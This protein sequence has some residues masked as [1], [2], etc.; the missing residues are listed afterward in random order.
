MGKAAGSNSRDDLHHWGK[1]MLKVTQKTGDKNFF[2]S[3]HLIYAGFLLQFKGEEK[4]KQLLDQGIRIAK[5][6]SKRCFGHRYF[7]AALCLSRCQGQYGKKYKEAVEWFMLQADTAKEAQLL[8]MAIGAYK[9]AIFTAQQRKLKAEYQAAHLAGYQTGV[10]M[11]D[12]ELKTTEYAF[13]AYH[14]LKLFSD[15]EQ[16]DCR[17]LEARMASIY[18]PDWH[19]Q[20]DS[21]LQQAKK[22]KEVP[23]AAH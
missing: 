17:L 7:D 14:F 9:T 13:I 23:Y 11:D 10:E 4:T 18:G 3:A 2:A 20:V 19:D 8:P 12:E 22:K 15:R 16:E 5:A 1:Q 6:A 21:L